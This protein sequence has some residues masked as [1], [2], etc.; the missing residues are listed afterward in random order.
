VI[1]TVDDRQL[2]MQVQP[3]RAV[4]GDPVRI[5][6]MMSQKNMDARLYVGGR[7]VATVTADET[8]HYSHSVITQESG[9]FRVELVSGNARTTRFI[10]VDPKLGVI[11]TNI[12]ET[13]S[14]QDTF[15]ACATVFRSTP[16]QVT[17][18]LLVDGQQQKQ[19]TFVVRGEQQRCFST[20]VSQKG[21]HDVTFRVTSDST[22]DATTQQVNVLESRI[23]VNVFPQDITLEKRHAG[24][25]QVELQNRA[26]SPRT[27]EIRVDGLSGIAETTE[28]QVALG[29]SESRTAFIRVVPPAAGRYDGTV[30]VTAEDV[31]FADTQVAVFANENPRLKGPL[32]RAGATVRNATRFVRTNAAAIGTVI[33]AVILVAI[34]GIVLLR[35]ARRGGVVEPRY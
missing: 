35:R 17:L 3:Q 6:G 12:P 19:E 15:D 31:T 28:K 4:V 2:T 27:F 10:Q 33:G 14:T 25:F 5:S 24:V 21:Q 18:T 20:L 11:D 8:K 16:G 30:T 1:G 22:Q 32:D 7:Y 9:V 13:V 26:P 23:E 29:S 34:L